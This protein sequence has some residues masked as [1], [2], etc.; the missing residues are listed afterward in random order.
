MFFLAERG[1]EVMTFFD[2]DEVDPESRTITSIEGDTIAYD[3]AVVVLTLCGGRYHLRAG[4]R[5]G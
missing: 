3:M 5:A 1:T 2:V 4:G